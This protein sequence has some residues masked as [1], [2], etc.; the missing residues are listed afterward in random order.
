MRKSDRLLRTDAV[1]NVLDPVVT[2]SKH[3]A[4]RPPEHRD[5]LCLE[6]IVYLIRTGIPWSD[7]PTDCGQWDAV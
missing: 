3:K 5:R 2:E 6:A 4:G 1:W 7:L